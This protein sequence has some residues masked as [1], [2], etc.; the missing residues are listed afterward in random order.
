MR[1]HLAIGSV[2]CLAL[3]P[4]NTA[5][6]SIVGASHRVA[7]LVFRLSSSSVKK[8]HLVSGAN[9]EARFAS[10]HGRGARDTG[11]PGK[12]GLAADDG[13]HGDGGGG[14]GRHGDLKSERG[15][16]RRVCGYDGRQTRWLHFSGE[17]ARIEAVFRKP[18]CDSPSKICCANGL[19]SSYFGGS[20]T[21]V[22]GRKI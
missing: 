13:A 14:D 5:V 8:T 9:G 3:L 20:N 12:E 18:R 15:Y 17:V 10:G 1:Q 2:L 6:R 22:C 4:S 7:R 21:G 11:V 19:M 16:E